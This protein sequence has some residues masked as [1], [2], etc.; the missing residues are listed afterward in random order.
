MGRLIAW[1]PAVGAI[2][3]EVGEPY[4]IL[5]GV[6]ATASGLAFYVTTDG[7]LKAVDQQN[8]RERLRYRLPSGSIGA[9][10]TYLGPDGRQYLA[11]L[12]G[13]GG[14]PSLANAATV[15]SPTGRTPLRD[16]SLVL[17]LPIPEAPR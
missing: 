3:W 9:P 14:W 11:V 4:P 16:S 15:A 6:L 13:L 12:L 7:W 17:G 1:D 10:M 8:G 2:R 5:G